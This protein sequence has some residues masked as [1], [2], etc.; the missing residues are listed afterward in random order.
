VER[1]PNR[2]R[3]VDM[4]ETVRSR[5]NAAEFRGRAKELRSIAELS[6]GRQNREI[7]LK[8]AAGYER[9]ADFYENAL[10]Q[11]NILSFPTNESGSKTAR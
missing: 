4:G 2:D 9:I 11:G 6:H 10:T 3:F 8:C 5:D 1:L 7:L